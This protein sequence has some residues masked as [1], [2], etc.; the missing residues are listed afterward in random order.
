MPIFLSCKMKS[1]QLGNRRVLCSKKG[2]KFLK[3]AWIIILFCISKVFCS[4][5]VTRSG[6][7]KTG[8]ILCHHS[9]IR[10]YSFIEG[11]LFV[12]LYLLQ[13]FNFLPSP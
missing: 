11:R 8:E 12:T 5:A 1:Q 13:I 4:F 2:K 3:N 6:R 7:G 10:V 9:P